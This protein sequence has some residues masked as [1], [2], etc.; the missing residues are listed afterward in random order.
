LGNP[1]WEVSQLNEEEFFESRSPEIAALAGNERKERILKLK[2]TDKILWND[3]ESSK[4]QYEADNNFYK[5]S[6][7]FP[8]TARGKINTYALFSETI[9]FAKNVNGRAGFIVPTGIATDDS[10]KYYF[11]KISGS[12]LVSLYDFENR[13]GIFPAVHRM[14][15]FCLLSLGDDSCADLSF[16]LTNTSQL[17]DNRRHFKL[18]R[19]EFALLN[20]NTRTCPVFRSE[21]DAE[22]TKKIYRQ[23]PVLI[24]DGATEDGSSPNP[25]GVHFK[26]GLFNMT[27]ASHLFHNTPDKDRLPLYEA[28]LMH[29]FDHRWATY[30]EDGN[31]IDVSDEQKR[32]INF[33]VRPRYWIDKQEVLDKITDDE[34]DK[35]NHTWLMGWR[36][37]T[38]AMNERTLIANI[39]PISGVGD[40]IFLLFSTVNDS[41]FL[42]CLYAE[43]NSI[44][45]DFCTRQK[46]GGTNLSFYYMSQLPVLPPSAYKE[47]DLAFIVPRVLELTYTA[48]DIVAFAEDIWNSSD[49]SMRQL[50]IKQRYGADNPAYVPPSPEFLAKQAFTPSVLEPFV[51]NPARRAILR[52]ELDACYA[53]LY[54]LTRDELRYIL[55]PADVMGPD[56]PSETFRVLK[57]KEMAEYGE[58]RT[59]RLVL[60]AWGRGGT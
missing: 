32:D 17:T 24:R 40:N 44:V 41:R 52:A 27:S 7:R 59:R 28:K 43:Q 4:R 29:Q 49:G 1:P 5:N 50:L 11:A 12:S 14:T 10:T 21:K 45:H 46:I 51:F 26:Q 23:V 57:D 2:E 19:E 54:G 58:F 60:E 42:T 38:N 47:E 18:L 53:R 30:S 20:P 13:E 56:Y 37:I 48:L 33:T 3:Y 31:T 22:L 9:L 39:I 35:K 8:L 16:F 55:D 34:K 15:K 36:R 25:W 6:D